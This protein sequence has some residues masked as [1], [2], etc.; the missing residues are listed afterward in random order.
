MT[1]AIETTRLCK[2]FDTRRA[3]DNVSVAVPAGAFVSVFGPNGAGKT[4]LLR[5]LVTLSRPSSG[6]ARVAG[7]D[8]RKQADEVRAR[9]GLVG[10]QPML[11]SDLTLEENLR[12]F[13][14]LYGVEGPDARVAELLAAV[15][16]KHRRLDQVRTFSRGMLQR[17][18]IARALVNDPD[19]L[20]LDEPYTGLDQHAAEV[21]DDLVDGLVGKRTVVMVSHDLD[22]GF[23]LCTHALVL[24]RGRV[25]SFGAKQDLGADEFAARYRAAINAGV[26]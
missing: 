2:T 11:Y 4:T 10:H 1:P 15:G 22:K 6:T 19:V 12:F 24:A 18:A 21:L 17:A 9:I 25:V 13:A 23:E 8:V 7:Y 16:L 3:V 14:R 5:M 26:A 20:F